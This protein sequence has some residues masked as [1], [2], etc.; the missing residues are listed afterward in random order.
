M[1][2]EYLEENVQKT[3]SM[4]RKVHAQ[5]QEEADKIKDVGWIQGNRSAMAEKLIV[6]GLEAERQKAK[7]G[8]GPQHEA[9]R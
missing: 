5:I 7:D 8:A 4:K 9:G 1:V 3:Y 6:L 2:E